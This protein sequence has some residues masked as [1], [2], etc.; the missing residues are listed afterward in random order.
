LRQSIEPYRL[1]SLRLRF[2][3]F[4]VPNFFFV[5]LSRCASLERAEVATLSSLCVLLDR[6]DA[7]TTGGEF[8]DH[9]IV[10]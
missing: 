10:V 6:I 1:L 8:A 2:V 4:E 9:G 7:V 5:F 3:V